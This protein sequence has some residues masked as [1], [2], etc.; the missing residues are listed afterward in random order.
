VAASGLG[1][2]RYRSLVLA[3]SPLHGV[4]GPGTAVRY[5]SHRDAYLYNPPEFDPAAVFATL[6]GGGAPTMGPTGPTPE[7][8][9]RASVLDAVL[10]DATSLRSRLGNGDRTRLDHHLDAIRELELRLRTT[11]GPTGPA[12]CMTPLDPGSPESFRASARAMADL[13]AMAFACDLTRVVSIEF[14][15]PASHTDYPD[16]YSGALIYN[17]E[18][19]SFHEYEHNAGV[20]DTVRVGLRYFIS[21][22]GDFLSALQA[23][24]ETD[25]TVLDH[26]CVLGTSEVS[27]GSGHGFSDYPILVAGRANGRLR[28]PGVHVP[29]TGLNSCRVPLTCL[30]A[31]G[32]PHAAWGM[33]Q[34]RVDAPIAEILI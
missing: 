21:C 5:T 3:V 23:I 13:V 26:A 17:G 30:Q 9:A 7:E 12:S 15:S 16:V 33:E 27:N 6:F 8:L 24:P 4:S 14:S 29:A 31:M 20:D 32:L 22:F 28:Y 2:T 34:L 18:P 11:G 25:G 19:T 10:E 1:A